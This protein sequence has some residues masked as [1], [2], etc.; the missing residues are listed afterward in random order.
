M[1]ADAELNQIA[2]PC[3]R[4]SLLCSIIA[5]VCIMTPKYHAAARLPKTENLDHKVQRENSRLLLECYYRFGDDGEVGCGE[6]GEIEK[7]PTEVLLQLEAETTYC[8]YSCSAGLKGRSWYAIGRAIRLGKSLGIFEEGK[9]IAE[10]WEYR[11]RRTIAW[12]LAVMD[13]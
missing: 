7:S 9:F 6:Y 8:T 3:H 4:A 13:R 5:L 11:M 10:E 2:I 12:D 1:W